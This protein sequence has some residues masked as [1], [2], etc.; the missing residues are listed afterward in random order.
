VILVSTTPPG[1]TVPRNR[2]SVEREEKI[3]EIID[4]AARQ[5]EE[6][7]M[8]ALSVAAIARELGLAHNAIR[9]YFPTRD[10]LLVAAVR[11]LLE[12]VITQKPPAAGG[13]REQAVWFAD[14]LHRHAAL[15]AAIH[16]RAQS[17]DVVESF[18]AEFKELLRGLVAIWMFSDR[19]RRGVEVETFLAAVEGATLIDDTGERNAVV[20]C[21]FD[22]FEPPDHSVE[23]AR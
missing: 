1:A 15:R 17:S 20:R 21:A 23:R 12:R 16:E 22:A 14:E 6:G 11:R 4:V 8:S 10:H 2:F 3:A 19:S 13:A 18:V 5:L 7:G 9:W